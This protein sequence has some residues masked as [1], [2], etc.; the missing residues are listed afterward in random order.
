MIELDLKSD[1]LLHDFLELLVELAVEPGQEH[2]ALL[3]LSYERLQ[4]ALLKAA[5]LTARL[6]VTRHT[7]HV[8]IRRITVCV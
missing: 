4:V 8:I 7:S 2:I 3:L 1:P 6:P 5:H